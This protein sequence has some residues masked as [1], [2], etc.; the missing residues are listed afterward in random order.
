MLHLLC[1]INHLL[2]VH[3][4]N[5]EEEGKLTGVLKGC[6]C[7]AWREV[8]LPCLVYWGVGVSD[9]YWDRWLTS[10]MRLCPSSALLSSLS[11]AV[12]VSHTASCLSCARDNWHIISQWPCVTGE[13]PPIKN[14]A[15][16]L[17][18]LHNGNSCG[19]QSKWASHTHTHIHTNMQTH[20]CT[21]AQ[22]R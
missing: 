20:I 13:S 19:P 16:S 9:H 2:G 10:Q 3:V 17:S 15:I 4:D 14:W 11:V 21:L 1:I 18:T 7:C 5:I 8:T 22:K 6:C 12:C